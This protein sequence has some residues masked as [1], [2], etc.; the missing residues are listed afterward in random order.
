MTYSLRFTPLAIEM[1]EE[2]RDRRS[3][4]AVLSRVRK[5]A[6]EPE[7]QGKALVGDF[8]GL[9]SVRA[10][11]QRYRI[12]YRVE[13][14]AVVVVVIGVGFRQEGARR[15]VYRRLARARKK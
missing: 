12:V 2:I 8:Q 14:E 5:L 4:Q 13:R 9:R 11:G 7:K 3:R 10:A 15:D 6:A 1:L